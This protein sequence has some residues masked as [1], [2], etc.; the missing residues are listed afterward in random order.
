ME[1]PGFK[2]G[3]KVIVQPNK[4]S[5]VNE[6]GW[7]R[8]MDKYINK[9]YIVRDVYDVGCTLETCNKPGSGINP[10]FETDYW[11]FYFEWL[12]LDEDNIIFE[13]NEIESLFTS[14]T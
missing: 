8:H 3:D 4:F 7:N 13:E 11:I 6:C 2:K 5:I 10:K 14:I 9:K 1:N 12:V